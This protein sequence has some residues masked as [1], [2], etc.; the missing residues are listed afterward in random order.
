MQLLRYL[1]RRSVA[2][3]GSASKD[4]FRLS[5]ALTPNVWL[6]RGYLREFR[7]VFG[8]FGERE[9]ESRTKEERGRMREG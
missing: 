3:P 5:T 4:D 9:R 7:N 1:S 2:L 6:L 8:E